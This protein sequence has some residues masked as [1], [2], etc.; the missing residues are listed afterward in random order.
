MESLVLEDEGVRRL[1]R[2]RNLFATIAVCSLASIGLAVPRKVASYR[3]LKA[4][5]A[6]LVEMQAAIVSTQRQIKMAQEEIQGYQQA[7][8]ASDQGRCH[9]DF[10]EFQSQQAQHRR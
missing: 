7:I 2:Q 4:A 10:S 9:R 5:N 1:R 6:H 8:R 3:E